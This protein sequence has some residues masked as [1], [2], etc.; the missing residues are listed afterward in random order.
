MADQYFVI[1]GVAYDIYPNQFSLCNLSCDMKSCYILVRMKNLVAL[2]LYS[3]ILF[4]FHT[5]T[6][7]NL[8]NFDYT[9]RS[10]SRIINMVNH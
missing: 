1:V 8:K 2:N 5:P 10:S 6:V 4:G 7:E 3:L 9:S